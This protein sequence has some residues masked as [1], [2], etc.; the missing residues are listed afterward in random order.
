MGEENN[1][2]ISAVLTDTGQPEELAM[3]STPEEQAIAARLLPFIADK[4]NRIAE[5]NKAKELE[6]FCN[7]LQADN[8][9]MLEAKMEELRKQLTPPSAVEIQALLDQ[10]YLTYTV[11]VPG[12]GGGKEFTL[13]ELP[14]A[15]EAKVV[16]VL[17]GTLVKRLQELSS[18]EFTASMNMAEKLQRILKLVPGAAETLSDCIAVCLDPWEEDEEITG[19]WVRK[20][21]S[22]AR[23]ATVLVAQF[24]VSRLRDFLS[25]ASRFSPTLTM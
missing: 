4:A 5:G 23:M 12:A 21:L 3:F 9:E 11:R 10:E 15:V 25:L 24:E 7:K 8:K 18:V 14:M 6:V 22:M 1:N 16:K 2:D 19:D 17:D 13:C 20:H